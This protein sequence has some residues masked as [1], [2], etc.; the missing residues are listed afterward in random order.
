MDPCITAQ[1]GATTSGHFDGQSEMMRLCF[2]KQFILIVKRVR[3]A[4]MLKYS[5]SR[6]T[7]FLSEESRAIATE[8]QDLRLAK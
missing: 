8:L 7:R 5:Q 4:L 3:V 1:M 6:Q 2:S